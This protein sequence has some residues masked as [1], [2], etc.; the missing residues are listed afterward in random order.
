M[1]HEVRTF[2]VAGMHCGGCAGKIRRRLAEISGVHDVDVDVASGRVV[3]AQHGVAADEI[4]AAIAEAGYDA[5][6]A[7]VDDGQSQ[8][9]ADDEPSES[10]ACHL[11]D[12]EDDAGGSA[13]S[14]QEGLQLSISG[15]TCASFELSKVKSSPG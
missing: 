3:V 14:A 9:D 4:I 1:K 2:Q 5:A 8:P 10:A 7:D 11:P 6:P 15:A 12:D 13:A